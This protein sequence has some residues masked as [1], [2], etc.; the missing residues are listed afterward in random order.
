MSN[1]RETKSSVIA[2]QD[3]CKLGPGRSLRLL[4]EIYVK[5]DAQMGKDIGKGKRP[6]DIQI[7]PPTTKVKTLETWS[8]RLN[9][10]SRVK[11]YDAEQARIEEAQWQ[12]RREETREKDFAQSEQL[13][14]LAM[15]ILNQAPQFI[16]TK[17]KVIPGEDGRPSREVVT[18]Q[19]N[20]EL[21][22]SCLKLASALQRGAAGLSDR[23]D[24]T[25]GGQPI[26]AVKKV[27]VVK[28]YGG[29]K[30]PGK[31]KRESNLLPFKNKAN[32]S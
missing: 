23:L 21:A 29:E 31:I 5:Q 30:S 25:S 19:L 28:D 27:E 14:D 8:A 16:K 13:R 18:V 4:S 2:F 24:I 6:G 32:A 12:K 10:Q 3:Y 15:Q 26:G 17:K 1:F 20:A 22:L 9:W 7:P 11:E